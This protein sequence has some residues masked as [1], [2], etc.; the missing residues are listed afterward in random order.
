VHFSKT[1]F[2]CKIHKHE[3]NIKVHINVQLNDL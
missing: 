2:F 3:E 1:F